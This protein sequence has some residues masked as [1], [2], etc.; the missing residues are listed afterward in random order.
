MTAAEKQWRDVGDSMAAEEREQAESRDLLS[1]WCM[2]KGSLKTFSFSCE[3][4]F[5][6]P[7]HPKG[8]AS[9]VRSKFWTSPVCKAICFRLTSLCFKAWATSCYAYDYQ[10]MMTES[11]HK[12]KNE[13]NPLCHGISFMS[14]WCLQMRTTRHIPCTHAVISISG[15]CLSCSQTETGK[16]SAMGR[17]DEVNWQL[18][19]LPC[20]L[21]LRSVLLAIKNE[22]QVFRMDSTVTLFV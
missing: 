18:F 19:S 10:I 12:W 14:N 21:F 20:Y 5:V 1:S 7:S 2:L 15:S 11:N 22:F 4:N 9:P 6:L 17:S 16:I 8:K 13:N 3:G